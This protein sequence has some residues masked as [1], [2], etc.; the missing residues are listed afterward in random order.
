MES[1]CPRSKRAGPLEVDP[2][3][4]GPGQVDPRDVRVGRGHV[5]VA[6]PQRGRLELVAG[7]QRAE[8]EV[9]ARLGLED[10]DQVAGGI[11]LEVAIRLGR[12]DFRRRAGPQA[13]PHG[14]VA[15]AGGGRQEAVVG[16][17]RP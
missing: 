12:G 5:R 6:G 1:W 15:R 9:L 16:R 8:L 7:V 10:V 13:G 17:C 4:A 2:R 3:V 14:R 11:E